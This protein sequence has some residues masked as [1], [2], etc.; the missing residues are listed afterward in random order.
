[1]T[2]F[3]ER[4]SNMKRK[5]K[6]TKR[7]SLN[8]K[9]KSELLFDFAVKMTFLPMCVLIRLPVCGLISLPMCGLISLPMCGLI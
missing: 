5:I 8:Q 1:M 7:K 9:E 4:P 2:S 3:Q 6:I